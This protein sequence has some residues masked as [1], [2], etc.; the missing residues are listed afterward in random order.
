MMQIVLSAVMLIA[1]LTLALLNYFRARPILLN[2]ALTGA[3]TLV[4]VFIVKLGQDTQNKVYDH[5]GLRRWR[6]LSGRNHR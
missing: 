1:S 2:L 3:V 5:Y 4:G 6:P